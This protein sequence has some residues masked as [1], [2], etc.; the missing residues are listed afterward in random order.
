M[1]RPQPQDIYRN[2]KGNMYQVITIA[3]H[4]ETRQ[5]MVVYQ[6]LYGDYGVY[7]RPV[8]MFT[9]EVDHE[10]YPDVKHKDRFELI[11]SDA[12]GKNGR[13]QTET[14]ASDKTV[15]HTET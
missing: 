2:F 15:Q 3:V 14:L 5:E 1:H 6:G 4:S 10:K 12:A 11:R 7:C 13:S 9:S 8:D